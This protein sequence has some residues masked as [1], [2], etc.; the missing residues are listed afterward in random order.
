ML[1]M[2]PEEG[3]DNLF[4]LI[5]RLWLTKHVPKFWTLKGLVGLPKKDIVQSVNN[6]RPIVFIK[7]TRK[8]WT[9]M[10]TRRLIGVIKKRLQTNHC[11]GL[12]NKGT[13]TALIQLLNLLD[14]MQEQDNAAAGEITDAPM[15]HSTRSKTTSSTQMGV[16]IDIAMWLMKLDIGGAFVLYSFHTKKRL[17]KIDMVSQHDTSHHAMIRSLGFFPKRGCTR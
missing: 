4:K 7:V 2:L 8:L 3:L 13:D 6:L 10:V 1:K 11:G 12:A 16:P 15:E 5:N 17:G 14:D 9:S